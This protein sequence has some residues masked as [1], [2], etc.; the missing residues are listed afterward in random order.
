MEEKILDRDVIDKFKDHLILEERS[1]A[2]VEKYIRD[3]ETFSVYT[4]GAGITKETK[5]KL[6]SLEKS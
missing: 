2:T 4:G 3:V 5:F 6:D 1:G